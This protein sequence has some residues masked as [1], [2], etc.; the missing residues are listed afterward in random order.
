MAINNTTMISVASANEYGLLISLKNGVTKIQHINKDIEKVS[1]E[2]RNLVNVRPN[3]LNSR[4]YFIDPRDDIDTGIEVS[5]VEITPDTN[6]DGAKFQAKNFLDGY[7]DFHQNFRFSP[8][9]VSRK[10]NYNSRPA[11][12]N[13]DSFVAFVKE[14]FPIDYEN[15]KLIDP[16]L[17][18]VRQCF[19][20][21]S[22]T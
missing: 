10:I 4:H 9:A 7:I 15:W 13:F 18:N 12:I 17:T 16:T 14:A 11:T 22:L 20:V 6:G 21:P 2:V 19:T 8:G 5:I 3:T 1:E